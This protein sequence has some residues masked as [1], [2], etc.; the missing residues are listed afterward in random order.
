MAQISKKDFGDGIKMKINCIPFN[1]PYM[2][3]KGFT[4]LPRRIS[5]VV[6][7]VMARLLSVAKVG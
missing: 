5:M 4:I 7:L 2:T 3:G 1:W 6:W